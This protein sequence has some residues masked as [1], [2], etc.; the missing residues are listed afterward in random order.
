MARPKTRPDPNADDPLSEHTVNRRLHAAY[1]ARGWTRAEFAR[2]IGKKYQVVDRWDSGESTPSLESLELVAP[3]VGFSVH[4][5]LYGRNG[6]EAPAPAVDDD[7]SVDE[8]AALD[9]L[10]R[11]IREALAPAFVASYRTE[12]R[13]G[14]GRPKAIA[15]ARELAL[16]TWDMTRVRQ[17]KLRAL[18]EAVELGGKPATSLVPPRKGR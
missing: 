12:R 4:Q 18:A 16:D 15:K 9:E 13:T 10:T 14:V 17:G 5:L 8:R 6:H 7:M 11:E 2:K 3:L 1:L